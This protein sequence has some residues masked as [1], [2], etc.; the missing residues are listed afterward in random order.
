M[1]SAFYAGL[2]LLL[3]PQPH[4]QARQR[5]A[6]K[7]TSTR[8]S[9]RGVVDLS[10]SRIKLGSSYRQVIARLGRPI[11]DTT[12]HD[13]SMGTE[14]TVRTLEYKG[15]KIELRLSSRPRGFFVVSI[16]VTSARWVIRPSLVRVGMYEDQVKARLGTPY[17]ESDESIRHRYH[18]LNAGGDG[19]TLLEFE[20]HRLLTISCSYDLT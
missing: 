12:D 20:A 18:Y 8:A 10:V 2:F 17:G 15:L 13:D 3:V 9:R 16:E 11:S 5:S 19:W 6:T 14:E 4:L 7:P 1:R